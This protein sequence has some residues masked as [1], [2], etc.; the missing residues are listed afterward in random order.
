MIPYSPRSWLRL[1]FS[2]PGSL[3]KGVA[4]RIAVFGA[5]AVG[6][7]LLDRNG[8]RVHLPAGVHE[9]SAAVI[10][11][12]L[13]FRTNTGYS[14]FWEGRGLWGAIVNASRNLAQLVEGHV[15]VPPEER[16]AFLSWVVVFAWVT[17]RRLRAE[18][19]WPEIPRLVSPEDL[20]AL[21]AASHP[22]LFAAQRLSSAIARWTAERKV[23]AMVGAQAQG[24]VANLVDS[25]GACEKIAKT[26]SPLGHVLLMER[27]IA[28]YLAT[29]PFMLVTKVEH[30]APL[31]TVLI[32]YPI[33]LLDALGAALDDPFGHDPSH[34]PLTRICLT[35]ENDLLG[36][37]PPSETI[38]GV[39][40]AVS[41][42]DE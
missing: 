11:L 12:F 16:R 29:L 23:D 24:L 4:A 17:R 15:D 3:T 28:L 8:F 39:T 37:R 35:I 6:V 26:P 10:A 32:A 41:G 40:G 18:P 14:R 20:S 1:L 33:L 38:Y 36:T 19:T 9:T 25:L 31:A 7:V 13:A 30:L 5:I 27:F 21:K 34:L 2:A 22:P 42:V